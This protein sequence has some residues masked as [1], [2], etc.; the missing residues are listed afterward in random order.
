M[1]N[2]HRHAQAITFRAL[3]FNPGQPLL[4]ANAWDAASARL[5]ES[6]GAPAI[7]TTSAGVAWSLGCADGNVL[8]REEAIAAA[9]RIVAA[10]TVPVTVDVEAGYAD[11]AAGVERTVADV[12]ESGAVGINIEDGLLHPGDMADRISAARRAAA[13]SGVPLF[14]NA[15]TDVF[16]GGVA[17]PAER[18]AET[19][20]RARRYLDAGADGVFVP[21]VVDVDTIRVLVQ[22]VDGPVNVMVG[23]GAPTA[24]ALSRL[25]VARVSAGS[26]VAQASYAVAHRAAAE[27][28]TT[29]THAS[30]APA[31]DYA[32]MNSLF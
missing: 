26:G 20:R 24:A 9:A 8:A 28:L 18:L 5:I 25:G 6:A 13:R 17:A 1:D 14:I 7:A 29:G 23:P 27:L 16:L 15:R 30:L 19:L 21:G 2:R 4:L 11:S 10:V 31:V 12:V 22:E 32:A 3:H